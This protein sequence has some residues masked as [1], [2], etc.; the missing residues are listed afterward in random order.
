MGALAT[1]KEL[2]A[3]DGI[4]EGSPD[5][6]RACRPFAENCGFTIAES[7]QFIVLMDDALAMEM[8]AQV[9]GAV[10]DVFVNADGHKKSISAPGVGNYITV[11]KAVAA[12]AAVIG[13][14]AVKNRTFIQAHGTGTPQN[15]VTESHIINEAAKNFGID[16]FLVG[17][18]KSY[19]GHSIG[20]AAGDQI[21][22]SL[23]MWSS[24]F[25]PGISTIDH[26]ADDVYSSHLNIASEHTEVGKT[27]MDVGIINAKGF[28]GNNATATLLSPHVV[29]KILAKKHG[30]K[31]V[32]AHKA[33][34]EA[35]Q[36][37]AQAYDD[38]ACA[39]ES[40]TIYRF[41]HNVCGDDAVQ[42]DLTSM[43][44][45]SFKPKISLDITSPYAGMISD[46]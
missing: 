36:V 38:A 1:D 46:D 37:Q 7:S 12:A 9:F 42:M 3:L 29:E 28:G 31:V 44:V 19:L 35:V 26:L 23:G 30:S 32:S 21:I 2:L 25:F 17:A 10:T 33:K 6:R 8:G 13:D 45:E 11:A 24:G 40:K 43:T 5:Y 27:G 41:D 20:C 15:R 34:N 4:T 39:G 22:A 16:N 18:V 14:D